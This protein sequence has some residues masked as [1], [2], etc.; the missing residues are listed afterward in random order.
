MNDSPSSGER[1]GK[2]PNHRCSGIVGVVGLQYR[3]KDGEWKYLES[4]IIEGDN[5]VHEAKSSIAVS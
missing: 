5:P 3:K 1:T 4:Y 2:S